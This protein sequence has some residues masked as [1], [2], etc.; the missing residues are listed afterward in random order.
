MYLNLNGNKIENRGGLAMAQMLQV[1]TSLQ[2]LDLGHTDLVNMPIT[3]YTNMNFNYFFQE[4]RK[5]NRSLDNIDLQ[6]DVEIFKY[7]PSLSSISI[8]QLDG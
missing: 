4:N 6:Q 7:K 2:H 5:L 8:R 1:N 3:K